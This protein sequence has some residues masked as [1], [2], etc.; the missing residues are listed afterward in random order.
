MTELAPPAGHQLWNGRWSPD[1]TKIAVHLTER[2]TDTE[3]IAVMSATG[4]NLAVLADAGTYLA[5]AAWAPNGNTVYF[6]SSTGI[7]SVPVTGGA[8]TQISRAFAAF[9]LDV[10][11][12]G[13]R[14]S[15]TTNGSSNVSVLELA[16]GGV[17]VVHSGTAARFSPDGTRLAFVEGDLNSERFSLYT[18]ADKSVVDL[19]PAGTYLASVSWFAD[20]KRLAVTSDKTIDVVT[21]DQAPVGRSVLYEDG[22]ATT[23]VDVSPDGTKI[24]FRVNGQLGLSVLSGF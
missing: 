13:K 9:E 2:A 4:S 19:G 23:G 1:G 17:Q 21:V 16:D 15:Y 18:F 5:S 22:F 6:T 24:L 3:S 20:G 10:S 14:L 11:G 8:P 12:D 7:S